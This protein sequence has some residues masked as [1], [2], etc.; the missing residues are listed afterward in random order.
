M[1]VEKKILIIS[2]HFHPEISPRAF[3]AFELAKQLA[4]NYNVEVL[5]PVVGTGSNHSFKQITIPRYPFGR[6]ATEAQA[7]TTDQTPPSLIAVMKESPVKT[8]LRKVLHFILPGGL[9]SL[10]GF[11]IIKHR[12]LLQSK[13]HAIISIGLPLGSH[14]GA[15]ALKRFYK[16]SDNL[17]LDYGDPFLRNP[18]SH[19]SPFNYIVESTILKNANHVVVPVKNA[20]PAFVG[21]AAANKMQVI[22][23]GL[24]IEDIKTKDYVKNQ[25][26]TAAYAGLF[27][28]DI[29]DPELFLE[30]ILQLS[31]NFKL[32]FLTDTGSPENL[33]L[34]AKYKALDIHNRLE[35]ISSVPRA[36]CISILSGCDFVINFRNKSSIQSPSKLIDYTLAKR[37]ILDVESGSSDINVFNSF[38]EGDYKDAVS[39]INLNEYDIRNVAKKFIDLIEKP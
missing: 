31:S 13:Y 7:L 10:F 19:W 23:Q 16:L 8:F 21:I 9:S 11:S 6:K 36:E 28:K 20:L 4:K 3:R 17:V 33:Q 26:P 32:Q 35:I 25:I 15:C 1:S 27:Y 14:I 29:R 34:L 5:T 18:K 38:L 2:Y 39:P 30:K 24:N 22:P 12:D 37:P